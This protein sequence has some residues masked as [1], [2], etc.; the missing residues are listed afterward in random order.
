MKKIF[1]VMLAWLFGFA[2]SAWSVSAASSDCLNIKFDNWD[3]VCLG[4]TKTWTKTFKINVE[5][6]NLNKISGLTCR[7]TLPDSYIYFLNWCNWTF[8]YDWNS[9]KKILLST[10]FTNKNHDTYYNWISTN[11]NFRDWSWQDNTKTLNSWEWVNNSSFSNNSNDEIELSSNR[12]SPSTNQFVNLSIQTDNDYTGKL[13]FSAKYRSSSSSSWTSISNLTSS[14]YFSDYSDEWEDG[15]YKMRA[16]DDGE[17]TIKNLV[18]FRKSGYYRIYVKDTDGNESYAQI[19]VD[20]SNSSNNSDDEIELSSNRTSPST[21]QFVNLSIQT[22]NDYTGKLSFSAKYRSSSSSSWTSISNL[23]SS[24]YF[25]DYSDEWEDGYYKMRA[26]DDGEVTIKNLVKFRKSGY[27]RI[28]V[29]DT[30]GNESYIQFSVGDIDNDSSNSNVSWFTTSE[31]EKVKIVYNWWE[32]LI[33]QLKKKYNSLKK[34]YY[35]RTMSENFYEDM[36]DIINNKKSRN[37]KNYQEFQ[38][39]FDD[40]YDYTMRKI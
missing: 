38:E 8:K 19:S 4:I 32:D 30:D 35:W 9:T 37:L 1:W 5:K 6:N 39:A 20:V 16:S 33:D 3:S 18:K 2:L 14:T 31:L 27:Y 23:T 7:I 26:S 13:S 17:V 40:W 21:N 29:K 22:D 25:S 11:V 28:Y 10:T 34:D 24:T 36:E 12:T 15:Y